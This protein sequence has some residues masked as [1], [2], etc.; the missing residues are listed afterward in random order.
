MLYGQNDD[1]GPASA[2]SFLVAPIYDAGYTV[3]LARGKQ[4]NPPTVSPD[5][6]TPDHG[7]RPAIHPL[8]GQGF[9]LG[10]DPFGPLVRFSPTHIRGRMSYTQDLGRRL[11]KC[12]A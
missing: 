6:V 10:S 3:S 1:A 4:E 9:P 2:A 7:S 12:R 11:L 8:A 5:G